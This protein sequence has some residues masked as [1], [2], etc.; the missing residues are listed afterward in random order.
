M[1]GLIRARFKLNSDARSELQ[2]EKPALVLPHATS[3]CEALFLAVSS[4]LGSDNSS[5][6]RP[7]K[8]PFSPP[9]HLGRYSWFEKVQILREMYPESD[10]LRGAI[11]S[12][13]AHCVP[14]EFFE[15]SPL[16]FDVLRQLDEQHSEGRYLASHA[17][18]VVLTDLGY[19]RNRSIVHESRSSGTR[20]FVANPFGVFAEVALDSSFAIADAFSGLSTPEMAA[21]ISDRIGTADP[22]SLVNARLQGRSIDWN[23]RPDFRD[24]SGEA[25]TGDTEV[26][27]T[28]FLHATRD[29]ANYDPNSCAE[30]CE[31]SLTWSLEVISS[32]R[33]GGNSFRVRKHPSAPNYRDEDWIFQQVVDRFSLKES[34][35][36]SRSSWRAIDLSGCV[37]TLAGTVTLEAVARGRVALN[38]ASLFPDFVARFVEISELPGAI[39]KANRETPNREAAAWAKAALTL[40]ELPQLREI[41]IARPMMPGLKGWEFLRQDLLSGW[42]LTWRLMPREGV[43][44]LLSAI[45][46]SSP[47]RGAN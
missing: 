34:S 36:C 19:L 46:H 30:R 27:T 31:D 4:L 41:R 3:D 35:I 12:Y 13:K 21:V 1:R 28:V 7:S 29:A 38:F 25:A 15:R 16:D 44:Q 14:T 40:L 24:E 32:L 20:I 45:G 39:E 26:D 2:V 11:D 22:E 5:V 23:V 43:Q 42:A 8:T 47:S 33:Q 10:L 37:T 9:P 6:G 18:T 17:R